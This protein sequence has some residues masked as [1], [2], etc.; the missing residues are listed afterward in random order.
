[1]PMGVGIWY[2]PRTD[3]TFNFGAHDTHDAWLQRGDNAA[4]LGL[5]PDTIE[6]IKSLSAKDPDTADLIRTAAVNA[7]MVRVRDYTNRVS[8]QF[9]ARRGLRDLIFN[10]HQMLK[11]SFGPYDP[12]VL[13]NMATGETVELT[14]SDM[15]SR[16]RDDTPI[17]FRE[18]DESIIGDIPNDPVWSQL[19][20]QRIERIRAQR[21]QINTI[22]EDL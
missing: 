21:K 17:L 4:D 22:S 3:Q 5:H 7:G 11:R 20:E 10:I 13:N 8:V 19:V 14:V 18:Q 16:L 6:F 12:V 9:R 2:N 15:G 1:M